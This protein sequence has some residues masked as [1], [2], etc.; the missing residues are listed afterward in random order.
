MREP[1][2]ASTFGVDG[3]VDLKQDNDQKIDE[4]N[5]E[6]GL[7]AAPIIAKDTVIVGRRTSRSARRATNR[8]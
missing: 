3:V 8:R 5:N 2:I 7:H 6:I 1:V 4:L